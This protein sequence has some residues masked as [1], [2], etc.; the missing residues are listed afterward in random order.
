MDKKPKKIPK[1]VYGRYV[2]MNI[3]GLVGLVLLLIIIEGFFLL[4]G[5]IFWMLIALWVFKDV[6][7]FPFVWQSYLP[8]EATMTG[9]MIGKRGVVTKRLDPSGYV[10]VRGELWRAERIGG[11]AIEEGRPVRIKKMEGL[12]LYVEPEEVEKKGEIAS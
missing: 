5:W 4:S 11:S 3:P 7:L 12:L 9:T 2:L 1:S 6:A 8:N 10:Q